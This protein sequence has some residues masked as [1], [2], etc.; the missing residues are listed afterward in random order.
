MSSS[1]KS[2]RKP[3]RTS[4]PVLYPVKKATF[5]QEERADSY[6]RGTNQLPERSMSMCCADYLQSIGGMRPIYR[7]TPL[8]LSRP[9]GIKFNLQA[10]DGGRA[11]SPLLDD[12][13]QILPS[14]SCAPLSTPYPVIYYGQWFDH[15]NYHVMQNCD[16]SVATNSTTAKPEEFSVWPFPAA[17]ENEAPWLPNYQ[18]STLR[19]EDP[20]D[21]LLC[22]R[23]EDGKNAGTQFSPHFPSEPHASLSSNSASFLV[24]P[25]NPVS[26]ISPTEGC[27]GQGNDID[28]SLLDEFF[29]RT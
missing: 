5:R 12:E 27:M 7:S 20:H 29:V 3:N 10:P 4:Q 9:N 2:K 11:K 14:T 21:Q 25:P 23:F 22:Q 26:L 17:I 15:S 18:E 16:R 6:C 8:A 28:Y 24:L 13:C 19:K 1:M